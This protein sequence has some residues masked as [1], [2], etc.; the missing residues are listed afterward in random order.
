MSGM[1]HEN[2]NTY[3]TTGYQ[4]YQPEKSPKDNPKRSRVTIINNWLKKH[5]NIV[6]VTLIVISS[7]LGAGTWYLFSSLKYE[8]LAG[9]VT[10]Q[11]TEKKYY[12]KLTGLE[13]N[14]EDMKR[15]VTAVMVENSPQARPQSG[16]KEAGVVYES[17]AEAGITR[18][19]LVYKEA[20][21]QIIG[22][23]RSVRPQFAS[24]VAPYDAGLAH[25]GGS[26][27]PLAKLR[28]GK[29]KDLDQF[30]S[31]GAYT[32][33]NNRR[34]PHNLYTSDEKLQALNRAKKYNQSLFEAFSRAK[35]ENPKVTPDAKNIVVPV[36][37]GLF[38]TSYSWDQATNSYFRS[39]GGK[40]HVD[41]EQGQIAPK[42]VIAMRVPHNIIRDS[43]GYSY[44]EVNGSGEAWVF[45]NGTVAQINW[46]KPNDAA[47]I[48]FT[49]KSG[50]SF[51]LNAGQT[52]IAAIKP[53]AIPSWN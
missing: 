25:V 37:T 2:K 33:S 24:W 28:S 43:N 14:E 31:P 53:S 6:L 29:I 38:S 34:A 8:A 46:E 48:K 19:L 3:T 7:A 12:S 39:V 52:W 13:T 1:E 47:Q 51:E 21:P 22:P 44:P 10:I 16:I 26:D 27:I 50:K 40:P 35:K 41:R 45:Q 18:F 23:V 36:S 20:K 49:D 4:S 11:A 15:P 17:V 42:T 30:Y 9:V 5:K 32:R